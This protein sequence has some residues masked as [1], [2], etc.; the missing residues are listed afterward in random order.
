MRGSARPKANNE[1][2]FER[3]CPGDLR[4]EGVSRRAEAGVGSG[5]G[6]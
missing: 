4:G 3:P 1:H 6:D 5:Q 2:R